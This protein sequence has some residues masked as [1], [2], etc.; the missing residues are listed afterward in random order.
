MQMGKKRGLLATTASKLDRREFKQTESRVA[1]LTWCDS[2]A[3]WVKSVKY[4]RF[5]AKAPAQWPGLFFLNQ[6]FV[7]D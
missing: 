5:N 6:L 1:P 4:E 3:G 7:K 2:A